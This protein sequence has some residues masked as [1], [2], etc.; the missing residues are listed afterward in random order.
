MIH[1]ALQAKELT[2]AEF[3]GFMAFA[4][5]MLIFACCCFAKP[6]PPNQP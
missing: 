5:A 4:L 1:L 2:P 6:K 3:A